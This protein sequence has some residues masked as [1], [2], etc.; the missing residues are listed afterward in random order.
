MPDHSC[1]KTLANDFGE[2]FK[3][4]VR[5][6]LD[7]LDN[8]DPPEL[9]VSLDDSCNCEFASFQEVTVEDVREILMKSAIKSSPLDPIP[10][11]LLK[12]CLDLLLPHFT[13]VINSSLLSGVMPQSLK[14]AQVTPLVKKANADRNELKNYRPYLI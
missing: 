3:G 11:D 10:K 5:K 8:I 4:K 13:R 2:F 7:A 9:S 6:L 14:I 12:G 1:H